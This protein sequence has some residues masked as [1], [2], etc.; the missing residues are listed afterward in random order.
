[1]FVVW[2]SC[3]LDEPSTDVMFNKKIIL[4][5]SSGRE[6]YTPE[7]G[8]GA[9]VEFCSTGSSGTQFYIRRGADPAKNRKDGCVK[10]SNRIVLALSGNSG[11][12]SNCG[13]YGCRKLQIFDTQVKMGH[14]GNNPNLDDKGDLAVSNFYL[15]PP[16]GQ[17]DLDDT[18]IQFGQDVV[19]TDS[20][21]TS[22]T[23]NCGWYGCRKG[24]VKNNQLVFG[25]NGKAPSAT[26]TFSN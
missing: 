9:A 15:R 16:G 21:T 2:R 19:L 26:F 1:M 18:C 13:W 4:R 23:Y 11:K 3:S 17:K 24:Q 22:N 5:D 8:F 14:Q 12:T 25:H 6:A 10:Y 7:K 20:S